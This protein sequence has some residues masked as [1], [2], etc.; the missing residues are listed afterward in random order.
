MI[1]RPL[2]MLAL[3]LALMLIFGCGKSEKQKELEKAAKQL[4]KAGK[5]MAEAG[6]K[7]AHGGAEAFTEGMKKMG[8]ALGGGQKVEPVDFRDLKE[9]LPNSLSGMK[10]TDASGERTKAFG[11]H[12]SKAEGNY[13][14]KDG[15]STIDIEITDMGSISGLTAMATFAWAFGEIDRETDSGYEKTTEYSGHRAFEEYDNDDGSGKIQVLVAKRF[16]VEV[17][18]YGVKMKAIKNALDKINIRKLEK[19]KDYGVQK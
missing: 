15:D 16:M 2:N 18:G 12:V 5:E 10:R 7:M 4:E 17:E 8:K 6:E 3:V 13:E 11:I 1:T 9:L 19:M 14:S